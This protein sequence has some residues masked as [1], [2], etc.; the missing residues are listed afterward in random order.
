[1]CICVS[2]DTYEDTYLKTPPEGGG[3]NKYLHMILLVFLKNEPEKHE[4]MKKS[5]IADFTTYSFLLTSR[6]PKIIRIG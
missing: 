1:M 3:S 6:I 4:K 2:A 5:K